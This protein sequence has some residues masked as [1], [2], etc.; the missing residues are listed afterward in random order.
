MNRQPLFSLGFQYSVA[1]FQGR[2]VDEGI[3]RI[4]YRESQVPWGIENGTNPLSTSD[5][6]SKDS[7]RESFEVGYTKPTCMV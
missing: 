3:V 1:N 5:R 2:L 7:V 6:K 4:F